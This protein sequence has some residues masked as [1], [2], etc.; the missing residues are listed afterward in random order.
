MARAVLDGPGFF[1]ALLPDVAVDFIEV[2]VLR[3]CD[4]L[5]GFAVAL[6]FSAVELLEA[7]FVVDFVVVDCAETHNG[8]DKIHKPPA[9]KT[10]P[11]ARRIIVLA[12]LNAPR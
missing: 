7:G 5:V 11:A 6:D 3:V 1:F 9:R 2:T 4:A 10:P 8:I 12:L